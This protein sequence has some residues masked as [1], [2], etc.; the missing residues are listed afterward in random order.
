MN[1]TQLLKLLVTN[2]EL[3]VRNNAHAEEHLHMLA[4]DFAH[5]KDEEVLLA[6]ELN[7]SLA[8]KHL[9]SNYKKAIEISLKAIDTFKGSPHTFFIA[10][11][12]WVVGHSY[13]Q[14]GQHDEAE[15][16]LNKSLQT[17]MD[18]EDSMTTIKTDAL[19]ALAMNEEFR[20]GFSGSPKAAEYIKQGL[21][22]LKDERFAIRR[23]GC[24]MGLGNVVINAGN[25]EEALQIYMQ[26]AEIYEGVF[27]LVNMAAVYSNI[28]TC[29]I[30]RHQ[31]D[32][33]EEYLTKSLD[34]RVKLGAPDETSISY[35][36]L[37]VVYKE[38]NRLA[39]AR[40]LLLKSK[41]I[42][43]KTGNKPHLKKTNAQLKEVESLLQ[44]ALIAA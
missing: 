36:N 39:D 14:L 15:V 13:I 30:Q 12:Y 26:A 8:E 41:E 17:V 21:E 31:F 6:L 37:A 11:H 5:I 43:L 27:D 2:R 22:L 32:K 16:N 25:N 3:I 23:A 29:Y 33:A 44:V 34:L 38:T 1:T 18:D 35:Y 9:H 24:L 4:E 42:L 20:N 10:R 28:G 40:D 19:I 7:R